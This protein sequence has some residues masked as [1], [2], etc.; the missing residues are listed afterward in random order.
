MSRQRC[1]H[2][3]LLVALAATLAGCRDKPVL[4][5][6]PPS[7]IGRWET[8]T[9]SHRD[10]DMT[11]SATSIRFGQGGGL[12]ETHV[13]LGVVEKDSGGGGLQYELACV[14]AFGE[15]YTLSLML[16]GRRGDGI[17]R[18]KSQSSIVWRKRESS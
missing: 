5:P 15:S 16:A 14:D 4:H 1:A 7:L 18:I 10:R 13:V 3:L 17:L 12:S 6:V 9:R 11:I 8:G 2:S